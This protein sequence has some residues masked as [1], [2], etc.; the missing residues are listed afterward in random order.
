MNIEQSKLN[1]RPLKFV[2]WVFIVSII[3][4]FAGLTSGY[5]V[6]KA[7]GNWLQF[8]LPNIFLY[9]TII[10][11]ASSVSLH[12][13]YLSARKLNF[14]AQKLGLWIT[15]VL[16]ILFL[17]GQWLAWEKLIEMEI[18][19]VGNP[20]GSFLYVISGLHGLH[21]LA[22]LCFIINCLVGAYKN[23]P[24]VKNIFQME[25]TSIFWH[26][27]DILWI[28]LYVFLLLNH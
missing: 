18:F 1:T 13:A 8:T 10:I 24:Q 19:L 23:T 3:M 25:L 15:L 26:F 6:R 22:G 7:E 2:M 4:M 20:S 28:Y 21:I 5:I 16:G 12:W 27:V 9:T 11:M 17:L 14:A